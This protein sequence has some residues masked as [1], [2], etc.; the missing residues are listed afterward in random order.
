MRM[1]LC[2]WWPLPPRATMGKTR[3]TVWNFLN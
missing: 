2:L 3:N 1:R